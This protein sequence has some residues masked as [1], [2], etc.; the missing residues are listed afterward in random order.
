VHSGCSL[1]I[2]QNRDAVRRQPLIF[3]SIALAGTLVA[4]LARNRRLAPLMRVVVEGDSMHPAY[5]EGDR[6]LINRWAYCRRSPVASEI[7]VLRDPEQNGRLL[8]KRVA[9]DV[10]R[11]GG[12]YVLGDNATASRDSRHFGA[13]PREAILGRVILRY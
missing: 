1:L 5:S 2:L 6:L 7:V 12:V 11:G 13:I 9:F 8:V 4:A 10:E 3:V